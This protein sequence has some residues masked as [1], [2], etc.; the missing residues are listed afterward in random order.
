MIQEQ[1]K[2]KWLLNIHHQLPNYPNPDDFLYDIIDH[3]YQNSKIDDS[4]NKN[5][6]KP[7]FSSRI[8][9]EDWDTFIIK[10]D[11]LFDSAVSE[12]YFTKDDKG[13]FKILK[14]NI[15]YL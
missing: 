5:I 9:K 14:N 11:S 12:G 10:S 7:V 8:K 3:L 13:K 4:F 1:L 2:L 15:K 6:L